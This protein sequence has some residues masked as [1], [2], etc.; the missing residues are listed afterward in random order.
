MKK[1]L[2]VIPILFFG[3][4]NS[5]VGINTSNPQRFF[6][7]DGQKD[8]PTTGAPTGPIQIDDF[9]VQSDG[10]VG[11]GNIAPI[12][13]VDLRSGEANDALAIGYT[14]QTATEA[15]AGAIRYL[16]E[17]GGKI[18]VSNGIVWQD[19]ASVPTKATV[20][21]R[22]SAG[23][24]TRTIPYNTSTSITNW[25][26][27]NDVTSN[28]EPTTGV[29]TAPRD[30]VY[31]VS[32]TFDFVQGTVAANSYVETQFYRTYAS[33]NTTELAVKC[34]K[35]WGKSTRNAQAGGSCVTSIGLNQGDKLHVNLLQTIENSA[36][37]LRSSTAVTN[38]FFGFNNLTIVEQ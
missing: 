34:L 28:F 1:Y 20:V 31:T 21:A 13:R 17:S 16:P 9:V 24:N 36:R 37:G 26:E 29:F 12:T 35:T 23:N 14:D 30:G 25:Q 11:A 4:A 6:H 22:I 19:L 18:Q 10:N 8:N 5:Q 38:A 3:I 33:N 15:G 32:F 27:V 7:V 2:L